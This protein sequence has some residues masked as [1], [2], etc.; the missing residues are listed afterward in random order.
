[1]SEKKKGL[2]LSHTAINKYK[3][4]PRS[5]Q[6]HYLENVRSKVVG[7]ALLFGGAMDEAL[8]TLLLKKKINL[9]DEEKD[10]LENGP[11]EVKAFYS[12]IPNGP[13]KIGPKEVF[14]YYFT[15]RAIDRDI[16][17]E[18]I[19]TSQY[20]DYY[21]SDFD[22]GMLLPEDWQKLDKFIE[23]VGYDIKDPEELIEVLQE[24]VKDGKNDL[25]DTSFLNYASWMTMYRKGLMMLDLFEAEILP[26]IE[27]VYSI[28]ER[29]DL[30]NEAGDRI[31][32]FLDFTGKL[33]GHEGTF[34]IDNKTSSRPYKKT[35]INEKEQLPLYSEYTQINQGAYIVMLKKPKYTKTKTCNDCGAKTTGQERSC[36]AEIDGDRCKGKFSSDI[37]VTPR[38]EFQIIT[39]KI[40]EEKKDLIFEEIADILEKIEE[41]KFEQNRDSCFQ[42]G[43]K[44]PYYDFCRSGSMEGLVRKG[45][46]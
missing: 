26:Q 11:K 27:E 25:T 19:R 8:N 15:Y 17:I 16:G 22:A 6:L 31:I 30:P 2:T 23:T 36:K 38:M 14:D 34:I 29:I 39:G 43:K 28:Q 42:F 20:I 7:S 18:D 10:T 3:A 44:C 41:G 21:K 12:M 5:F 40:S 32:G 37:E 45:K 46:K 35:D 9:T 13:K 24:K 4:C 33:V 1:M